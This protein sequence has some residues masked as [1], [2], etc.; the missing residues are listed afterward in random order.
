MTVATVRQADLQTRPKGF[1][2]RPYSKQ[3]RKSLVQIHPVSVFI[4]TGLVEPDCLC[5]IVW[6][7]TRRIGQTQGWRE[8]KYVHKACPRHGGG[9]VKCEYELAD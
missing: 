5:T 6:H 8:L 3:Q 4:I 2:Y 1:H 7:N 9:K